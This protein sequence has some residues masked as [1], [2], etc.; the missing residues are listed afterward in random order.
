MKLL[1]LKDAAGNILGLLSLT[2]PD[3]A[4]LTPLAPADLHKVLL[5]YD[6][7]RAVRLIVRTV[8]GGKEALLEWES[9]SFVLRYG[10]DALP[11]NLRDPMGHTT[12][13][14]VHDDAPGF[15]ISAQGCLGISP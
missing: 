3:S 1:R 2:P 9:D 12:L 4:V 7:N 13:C 6:G 11:A 14:L 10:L 5:P 8:P 15:V